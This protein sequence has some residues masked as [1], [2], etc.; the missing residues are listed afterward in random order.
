[1]E[2]TAQ[3]I[4]RA[5]EYPSDFGYSG[6]NEELFKTWTLGPVIIHRDSDLLTESNHASL[7]ASLRVNF[8]DE[9]DDDAQW[10]IEH[11][12]HWAVGWCDHLSFRL[13]ESDGATPTPIAIWIRAWFDMLENYPVADSEDFSEREYEY[14]LQSISDTLRWNSERVTLRDGLDYPES[15][16][17]IREHLS[18]HGSGE[19]PTE[20]H[21]MEK[22]VLAA[23]R[24]LGFIEENEDEE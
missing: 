7:L 3:E 22:H 5:L 23:A 17:A 4:K 19:L 2:Y 13:V 15:C 24:E 1:V 18:S 16:E 21:S 14:A 12:N 9:N 11:C 6:D 10:S 20:N 8:G